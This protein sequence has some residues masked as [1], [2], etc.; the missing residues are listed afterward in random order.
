MG[1]EGLGDE[2]RSEWESPGH[3][4]SIRTSTVG[5]SVGLGP[6]SRATAS[7]PS[8]FARA[9]KASRASSSGVR[10]ARERRASASYQQMRE[11]DNN[12][13]GKRLTK[14]CIS[15]SDADL[16]ARSKKDMAVGVPVRQ[17]LRNKVNDTHPSQAPC[18]L[19]PPPCCPERACRSAQG[20]PRARPHGHCQ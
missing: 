4:S 18:G 15:G 14:G 5:M 7:P 13:K 1:Y 19:P 2:R 20:R 10:F 9:Y 6:R 3:D 11:K 12:G 8:T 17:Q 16:C